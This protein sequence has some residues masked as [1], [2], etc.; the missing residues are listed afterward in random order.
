M[1]Y[2]MQSFGLAADYGCF[3]LAS[4]IGTVGLFEVYGNVTK[5]IM[6]FEGDKSISYYLTL[7]T[8]P[9]IVFSSFVAFYALVGTILSFLVFPFG[10]LILKNSFD[11]SAVS[12]FKFFVMIVISNIF[13][14]V[15]TLLV[16]SSVGTMGKMRNV[17]SRFIFPLWILG[18]FQFSW[19][20]I[21]GMSVPLS[22]IMLINPIVFVME[23]MRAS[24]LGQVGYIS[25]WVCVGALIVFII[26]CWFLMMRKMRRLLD[27]VI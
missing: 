7:P 1:G 14:G 23:G 4:I 25:W 10:L 24:L 9:I 21:Y 11:L 2:I 5:N 18:A 17:W 20:V 8:R 3:Q 22:Y 6:D 26:G 12:W 19:N 16:T 13:F 15:F 27:F